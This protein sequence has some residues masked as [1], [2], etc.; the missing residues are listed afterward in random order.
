MLHSTHKAPLLCMVSSTKKPD[1][2]EIKVHDISLPV[3]NQNSAIQLAISP[4]AITC[5]LSGSSLGIWR[6]EHDNLEGLKP[7]VAWGMEM[8]EWGEQQ[9]AFA[10][11]VLMYATITAFLLLSLLE[12]I[13]LRSGVFS[14]LLV[15]LVLLL[16]SVGFAAFGG[17]S[18]KSKT[19]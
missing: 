11:V 4:L 10:Q 19:A 6:G 1:T 17:A 3:V 18:K 15:N 2:E 16:V 14:P 9:A 5:T 8:L 7:C 12:S 13:V